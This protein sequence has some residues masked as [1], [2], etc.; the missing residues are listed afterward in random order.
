MFLQPQCNMTCTF[1]V[2]EDDFDSFSYEL[3]MQLLGELALRGVRSV[4]FGGGEPFAW[5]GDVVLLAREAK[6]MGL[7][8]QIGTNGV[9]VP[10]DFAELACIDRFVLPLESADTAIHDA[11]RKHTP[12]HH[13]LILKRL[14]A[15]SRVGR[16]VTLSTVLTAH[17]QDCVPELGEFLRSYHAAAENVH[18]WHLYQFLPLGR[19]GRRHAANLQIPAE[20]FHKA[21][22]LA[23]QMDL[24][25]RV[26]KR[27]DM[28]HSRTVEFFWCSDGKIESGGSALHAARDSVIG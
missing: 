12:S 15:L 20:D 17:N 18:A 9:A 2:T 23:K 10:A 22:A 28:Y 11:M 8:V 16:S 3:A 5:P 14:E 6:R 4:T 25:F 7:H 27:V 26:F 24:P 19:G 21:C 13:A 1:C